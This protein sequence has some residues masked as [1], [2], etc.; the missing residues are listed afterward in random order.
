MKIVA[1]VGENK[2]IV[3]ASQKVSFPVQLIKS[4]EEF[5]ELFF[6]NKAQAYVRGSLSSSKLMFKLRNRNENLYRASFLELKGNKFLL[7]PVGIDEG[8][9][10]LQ[11]LQI[12]DLCAEFL[13][14]I[15]IDPKI[16]I[17]S[18]GRAQDIG[19]SQ[20]IDESIAQGELL[21]RIIK[22]KYQ[23]KHYYILIE[24]AV[25]DHMN[26]ILAPDGI[27]GN[28]IFRSLI[29]LGSGKSHGAITL[30]IDKIFID[31][32]RSLDVEGYVRALNFAK[33]L[34]ELQK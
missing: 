17:L 7:A 22:D 29:L 26:V 18:S 15:N 4:E 28:L 23:V 13:K 34:A 31:T 21:T 33:Y 19:R 9:N 32:S 20:K 3:K 1:G 2:N 5:A 8:D 14:K 6:S 27:T 16:A 10:L 25:A 11:K 12:I 24:E 30:G